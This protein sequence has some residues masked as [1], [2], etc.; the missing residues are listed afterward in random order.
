MRHK[1]GGGK[2]SKR[3]SQGQNA[4]LEAGLGAAL[5][6]A[7]LGVF[8]SAQ[9]GYTRGQV[10]IA[11][12]DQ[13]FR[14]AATMA[15][16]VQA[17]Y[18]GFLN[19]FTGGT[20]CG[21][22][23]TGGV[24]IY[25]I[26]GAATS[27]LPNVQGAAG[28][29]CLGIASVLPTGA[30]LVNP[31]RQ[32]FELAVGQV[33]PPTGQPYLTAILTTVGGQAIADNLAGIVMKRIGSAGAMLASP[34]NQ[35][36]LGPLAN[37]TAG[38]FQLDPAVWSGAIT[39]GHPL[40]YLNYA[41]ATNVNQ[42]LERYASAADAAPNKMSAT[43][44]MNGRDSSTGNPV[45]LALSGPAI[46][47]GTPLANAALT[48]AAGTVQPRN[49]VLGARQV[50]TQTLTGGA[51]VGNPQPT[52]AAQGA[53]EQAAG[54]TINDGA[55]AAYQG[56][57]I[58][59]N[60]NLN[61]TSGYRLSA[62]G[63]LHV[64]GSAAPSANGQAIDVNDRAG[65]ANGPSPVIT[66]GS[67]GNPG[68]LGIPS[69][70]YDNAA[71]TGLMAYY[72]TAGAPG[73]AP[74]FWIGT[75]AGPGAANGMV[76]FEADGGIRSPVYYDAANANY[77]VKPAGN[78]VLAGDLTIGGN[79]GVFGSS[80]VLGNS[81]VG[82]S[83]TITGDITVGGNSSV[84][85]TSTVGIN[86]NIG[87]NE[88]IGLPQYPVVGTL[89]NFSGCGNLYA[90][91][92][93]TAARVYAENGVT[94]NGGDVVA[95]VGNVAAYTG[96][97][98]AISGFAQVGLQV[99]LGSA[100]TV[101]NGALAM[102]NAD[103]T[104]AWCRAG[105][106]EHISNNFRTLQTTQLVVPGHGASAYTALNNTGGPL[107]ATTDCNHIGA[108]ESGDFEI[109]SIID[110][111]QGVTL[112]A[113]RVGDGGTDARFAFNATAS[114]IIPNGDSYTVLFEGGSSGGYPFACNINLLY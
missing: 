108:N 22:T 84:A 14:L 11:A 90:W 55:Y 17:N 51:S 54:Q 58:L 89:P 24:V 52:D 50:D 43:L 40:V 78:S 49:A 92:V 114:A 34:A 53:A 15:G 45:N 38:R 7:L 81:A 95:V 10:A 16:Y 104:A 9:Q 99:Q 110:L 37:G 80:T 87:C 29:Q 23:L 19:A 59:A 76:G 8:L 70:T 64:T 26:D 106:W 18:Q 113:Q 77:Y 72:G 105:F 60:A 98:L 66:N 67:L 27:T 47:F 102:S 31:Y 100:C 6:A 32:G 21:G 103:Q 57:T 82:G 13:Q 1:T 111:T 91:D 63:G 68:A 20:P 107:M 33:V 71:G 25:P 96:N 30:P 79:I 28:T 109:V 56:H 97:L 85:G 75:Y 74:Q 46:P 4:V 86:S 61:V 83:A 88:Y 12:G 44:Y 42:N 35:P 48:N 3:R 112:S 69:I 36:A 73:T 41:L 62:Q 5:A 65:S 93:H 101:G 94:A 2:A 39:P